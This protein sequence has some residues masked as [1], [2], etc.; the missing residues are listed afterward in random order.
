MYACTLP[1]EVQVER[2]LLWLAERD[3]YGR[4]AWNPYARALMPRWLGDARDEM[5]WALEDAPGSFFAPGIVVV[6]TVEA[7]RIV[8]AIWRHARPWARECLRRRRLC[9]TNR[10]IEDYLWR[11]V[12][13]RVLGHELGHAYLAGSYADTP[14][15]R[16]EAGADYI[17]GWLDAMAG[18][19]I[20]L[21]RLVFASIGCLG[22]Y[23]E[24]PHPSM[25]AAAYSAG[26]AAYRRA[27]A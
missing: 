22:Q 17:A 19:S 26:A 1:A 18:R 11:A 3:I 5:F 16:G 6:D 10:M 9:V 25:R 21:G 27:A 15:G 8:G 4:E 23:C 20:W 24:H 14:Y 7:A 13:K 2:D 12:L